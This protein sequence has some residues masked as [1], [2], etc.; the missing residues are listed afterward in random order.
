MA[1]MTIRVFSD[2]QKATEAKNELEVSGHTVEG[3]AQHSPVIWDA[4]QAGA[5]SDSV[6]T[7]WV[8]IA[9]K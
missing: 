2:Q 7:G 4:T 9:R 6:A 5:G 3:P 8:V 1:L